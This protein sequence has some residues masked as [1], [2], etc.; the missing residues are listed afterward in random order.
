[1]FILAEKVATRVVERYSCNPEVDS[2]WISR[3]ASLDG[4]C[5][6][7]V[8][9]FL[10]I[11]HAPYFCALKWLARRFE[12]ICLGKKDNLRRIYGN[13]VVFLCCFHTS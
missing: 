12:A 10:A 2:R 8:D 3:S 6:W 1:M 13:V 9:V 5:P 7:T 11:L 4:H